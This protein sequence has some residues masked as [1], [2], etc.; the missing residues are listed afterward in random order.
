VFA[1]ESAE[2]KTTLADRAKTV[3]PGTAAYKAGD[4]VRAT[5]LL[6]EGVY[7]LPPGGFDREPQAWQTMWLDNARAVPLAFAVP[8]PPP[9][10]CNMLKRFSRPTFIIE[11]EKTLPYCG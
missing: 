4:P 5:R 1:S 8:P 9:V 10:T 3:G 7:Q 2:R 6:L 11:G